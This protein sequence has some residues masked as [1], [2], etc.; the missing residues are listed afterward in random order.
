VEQQEG[1]ALSPDLVVELAPLSRTL[2]PTS[3]TASLQRLACE[4]S[5][6]LTFHRG[7]RNRLFQRAV[8]LSS[9]RLN[10]HLHYTNPHRNRL[11]PPA[12][13]YEQDLAE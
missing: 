10:R 4:R 5:G 9:V 1:L 7:L 2:P 3:T 6:S 12:N 13:N 8:R 11:R